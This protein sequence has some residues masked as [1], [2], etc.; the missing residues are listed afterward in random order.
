MQSV[1]SGVYPSDQIFPKKTPP[2]TIKSKNQT[3][4]TTLMQA[5]MGAKRQFAFVFEK[6]PN[7]HHQK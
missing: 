1:A 7:L 5:K 3:V 2:A 4:K 6:C